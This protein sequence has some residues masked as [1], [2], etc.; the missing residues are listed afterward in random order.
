MDRQRCAGS[1]AVLASCFLIGILNI[2][3]SIHDRDINLRSGSYEGRNDRLLKTFVRKKP[4]PR[5]LRQL[6]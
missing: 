6:D 4:D 2:Y 5:K 1:T 3:I